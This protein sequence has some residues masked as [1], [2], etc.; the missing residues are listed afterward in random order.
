MNKLTLVKVG[1]KIVEEP[2]SLKQ[3]VTNFSKI[4]DCFF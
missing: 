1:G 4:K 2:Q 3:L